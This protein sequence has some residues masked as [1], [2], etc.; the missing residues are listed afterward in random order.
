MEYRG[1]GLP[2]G[3]VQEADAGEPS[4]PRWLAVPQ[5]QDQRG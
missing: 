5:Q 4:G 1:D 3:R 2:A